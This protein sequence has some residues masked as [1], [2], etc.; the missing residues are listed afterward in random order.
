MNETMNK[1]CP[2]NEI[3][4]KAML[5][6]LAGDSRRDFLGHVSTCPGCRLKFEALAKIETH[7]KAREDRIPETVLLD[8][9]ARELKGWAGRQARALSEKGGSNPVRVRRLGAIASAAALLLAA[10]GY[11]LLVKNP[12]PVQIFR[13]GG[14]NELHLLEPNEELKSAPEVFRWAEVAGAE[15]YDFTLIDDEL[16]ILFQTNV[17][18]TLV[19]IPLE[20][21]QRLTDET[22]YLWTVQAVAD[23]NQELASASRY[24]EI[25]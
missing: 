8:T 7:L 5:G 17:S 1:A 12:A 3:F 25:E 20:V 22:T 11:V 18:E 24:F 16:N 4:V 19:R 6:E 13:S 21:Q 15:T 9:E 23:N 10:A 2:E 14:G